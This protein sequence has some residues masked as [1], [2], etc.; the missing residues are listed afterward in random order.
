MAGPVK[1]WAVRPANRPRSPRPQLEETNNLQ[2]QLT[3]LQKQRLIEEERAKVLKSLG[4]GGGIGGFVDKTVGKAVRSGLDKATKPVRKIGSKAGAYSLDKLGDYNRRFVTPTAAWA[5]DG[6]MDIDQQVTGGRKLVIGEGTFGLDIQKRN[7]E[8]FG[9]HVTDQNNRINPIKAYMG[10]DDEIARAEEQMAKINPLLRMTLET[11]FDPTN[12]MTM[13]L[14]NVARL[15]ARSGVRLLGAT[16]EEVKAIESAIQARATRKSMNTHGLKALLGENDEVLGLLGKYGKA[17]GSS[18]EG[19]AKALL[20]VG[21]FAH[22]F[23]GVPE[24]MMDTFLRTGMRPL[25]KIPVLPSLRLSEDGTGLKIDLVPIGRQSKR[26][27]VEMAGEGITH[28]FNEVHQRAQAQSGGFGNQMVPSYYDPWDIERNAIA[29]LQDPATE[30][31]DPLAKQAL[32]TIHTGNIDLNKYAARLDNGE[33]PWYIQH[34]LGKEVGATRAKQLGLAVDK[35]D[36]EKLPSWQKF[37]AEKVARLPSGHNY[38]KNKLAATWVHAILFSP[39]Y[40]VQQPVT[41]AISSGMHYGMSPDIQRLMIGEV[42]SSIINRIVR[43]TGI[44]S[45]LGLKEGHLAEGLGVDPDVIAKMVANDDVYGATQSGVAYYNVAKRGQGGYLVESMDKVAGAA[46]HLPVVGKYVANSIS[47]GIRLPHATALANDEGFLRG[48]F[49]KF[50]G[51]NLRRYTVSDANEIVG[52]LVSDSDV[53]YKKLRNEAGLP[54]RLAKALSFGFMTS[55]NPAEFVDRARAISKI[56]PEKWAE[57]APSTDDFFVPLPIQNAAKERMAAGIQKGRYGVQGAM[58]TVKRQDYVDFIAETTTAQRDISRQAMSDFVTA[59]AP[60][61]HGYHNSMSQ[62]LDDLDDTVTLP[63]MR[64]RDAHK[65]KPTMTV[66]SRDVKIWSDV[67]IRNSYARV[68]HNTFMANVVEAYKVD[69]DGFM[70]NWMWNHQGMSNDVNAVKAELSQFLNDASAARY[71][72]IAGERAKWGDFRAKYDS[73]GVLP[74]E[75]D[76]D[77]LDDF[78]RAGQDRIWTEYYNRQYG[79]LGLANEHSS[80]VVNYTQRLFDEMD[81]MSRQVVGHMESQAVKSNKILETAYEIAYGKPMNP[82]IPRGATVVK[83]PTGPVIDP[84]V[85]VS[86]MRIESRH[87]FPLNTED[88]K[89]LGPAGGSTGARI[90]VDKNGQK[91]IL[92][93]QG[94]RQAADGMA[95][96]REE[97]LADELYRAMGVH[98]P[99]S[100]LYELGNGQVAKLSK[101]EEGTELGRLSG[102]AFERAAQKATGNF[103]V[104]V[105]LGNW[106]T[107]GL[108][109]DNM[110]LGADDILRRIDTGGSL[111]Y[112]AQGAP[113]G[114]AFG[115]VPGEMDSLR[116]PN[117]NPDAAQI[118]GKLTDD[119]IA[120]QI[121]RTL[122]PERRQALN[123]VLEAHGDAKLTATLNARWDNLAEYASVRGYDASAMPIFHLDENVVENIKADLQALQSE[124]VF[125]DKD[126][127]LDK[128]DWVNAI[129]DFVYGRGLSH[130]NNLI[131]GWQ[132]SSHK[133]SR[134]DYIYELIQDPEVERLR[135]ITRAAVEKAFPGQKTIKLWHG[136]NKKEP[137]AFAWTPS[138]ST[139]RGFAGN[140]GTNGI[141]VQRDVPIGAILA[142]PQ[143]HKGLASFG[144]DEYI[145]LPF[146]GDPDAYNKMGIDEILNQVIAD[147]P[148]G[149]AILARLN[150]HGILEQDYKLIRQMLFQPEHKVGSY[151]IPLIDSTQ[152]IDPRVMN[153]L[154]DEPTVGVMATQ[155]QR[156]FDSLKDYVTN[157][158]VGLDQRAAYIDAGLP[159]PPLNKFSN[160]FTSVDVNFG[161]VLEKIRNRMRYGLDAGDELITR[162]MTHV[163]ET[164]PPEIVQ[165]IE[166]AKKVKN[167]LGVR[168]LPDGYDTN[169]F[170]AFSQ[171]NGGYPLESVHYYITTGQSVDDYTIEKAREFVIK[172][173]NK[174][175]QGIPTPP[176][177]STMMPPTDTPLS[178]LSSSPEVFSISTP[179]YKFSTKIENGQDWINVKQRLEELVND[180]FITTAHYSNAVKELAVHKHIPPEFQTWADSFKNLIGTKTPTSWITEEQADNILYWLDEVHAKYKPYD[181]LENA[182]HRGNITEGK[183]AGI[184]IGDFHGLNVRFKEI[185]GKNFPDKIIINPF[186]VVRK[187]TKEW[188][189]MDDFSRKGF[190][191][192][193][194]YRDALADNTRDLIEQID[195]AFRAGDDIQADSLAWLARESIAEDYKAYKKVIDTYGPSARLDEGIEAQWDEASNY[196]S[197]VLSG[198][199]PKGNMSEYVG[200]RFAEEVHGVLVHEMAHQRFREHGGDFEQFV[201]DILDDVHV[202]GALRRAKDSY[203]NYFGEPAWNKMIA[204]GEELEQIGAFSQK[205]LIERIGGVSNNVAAKRAARSG[206]PEHFAEGGGGPPKG[207]HGPDVA[208]EG[209]IPP[210][211]PPPTGT[212]AAGGMAGSQPPKLPY[213]PIAH[214]TEEARAALA[215]IK[216]RASADAIDM[217]TERMGDFFMGRTNLDEFLSWWVPFSRFG[218][219]N[220]PMSMRSM[221]RVPGLAPAFA[222]WEAESDKQFTPT[223]GWLPIV[224]DV[225]GNPMGAMAQF[226]MF[227]SATGLKQEFGATWGEKAFSGAGNMGFGPGPIPQAGANLLG[228]SGLESSISPNLQRGVTEPLAEYIGGP[229]AI[230]NELLNRVSSL[231]YGEDAQGQLNREIEQTLADMGLNPNSVAE[232]SDEWNRAK[233]KT[234]A[235]R[236][237]NYI[238]AGATMRTIPP[239][240]VEYAK[241]TAEAIAAQGISL[242]AQRSLKRQGKNAWELLD[243]QQAQDVISQIGEEEFRRRAAVT[244][245]GLN[246][247]DRAKWHSIQAFY[248]ASN[249]HSAQ[250]DRELQT[251]GQLLLDGLIDGGEWRDRRKLSYAT[252][253][254]MSSASKRGAL[255]PSY[256]GDIRNNEMF[257]DEAVDAVFDEFKNAVRVA[258]GRDVNNTLMP[259]DEVLDAYKGI[260]PDGFADPITGDIDWAAWQSAKDVFV[261]QQPQGMRSYIQQYED[262]RISRDPAEELFQQAKDEMDI[263]NALPRFVG[264]SETESEQAQAA[265]EFEE[266]LTNAGVP[267]RMARIASMQKDPTGAILARIG[268]RSRNKARS[269]YWDEHPLLQLFFSSDIIPPEAQQYGGLPSPLTQIPTQ[270]IGVQ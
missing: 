177:D 194:K 84:T 5:V 252:Y 173:R 14:G 69:P 48:A 50:Y 86:A 268:R 236:L 59:E 64:F 138:E 105:L 142:S 102:D 97:A 38:F 183:F 192:L 24:I 42:N 128:D 146:Q 147:D 107:T 253:Y 108:G 259:Q 139:A 46:R 167:R 21:A 39:F 141:L 189:G 207:I 112:R 92:K 60:V 216:G 144:E 120:E 114:Q 58:D 90:V 4:S 193:P 264:L 185:T 63:R 170:T 187:I 210:Q 135:A 197:N 17:A 160:D 188:E 181:A 29:M 249:A 270:Q 77:A 54:N 256:G 250:L 164:T 117:I 65:K 191:P 208:D 233:R 28:L 247:A 244:P 212:G 159:V 83:G 136:G 95:H 228:I 109:L 134:W 143:S 26:S 132:G 53:I 12:L 204:H 19:M 231:V 44:S 73:Q 151:E 103:A 104:D 67:H 18:K 211:A 174:L 110:M 61:A 162:A 242:E 131:V 196:I 248:A 68:A 133:Y 198:P 239:E 241:K 70:D 124:G 56:S 37:F 172:K 74:V 49:E 171:A 15:S 130:L 175:T 6:I 218:T 96:L 7:R 265:I 266:S 156:Q 182:G 57:W 184:G 87:N 111:R 16:P 75:P 20:G 140:H 137:L 3:L 55:D 262:R 30:V 257:P 116:D 225:Y 41:N 153:A 178:Q 203:F 9:S 161:S 226:Q 223:P 220:I 165:Y 40:I 100:K 123:E 150:D 36:L 118:F 255:A 66:S 119:E 230:P 81:M 78:I 82:G 13:G 148:V 263:Y 195:A 80:I 91:Y 125:T 154:V 215:G 222:R 205:N 240:R 201:L 202:Q 25:G 71:T 51:D 227:R 199:A 258:A 85:N 260:R 127:L 115:D 219:R 94:G 62:V 234:V 126:F 243:S 98:V 269:S 267:S 179:E 217:G 235:N 180:G 93:A 121:S 224:G 246:S 206:V 72:G 31:Y 113:K 149:A 238:M 145:V 169:S 254:A 79:R 166:D 232:G 200:E 35:A 176:S 221:A 47:G 229:A 261:L 129:D 106:D 33:H 168:E 43:D 214:R 88:L 209:A 1:W 76:T 190:W 22:F 163:D 158:M 2:N 186:S 32:E 34:D 245:M 152:S 122:T 11:I 89:D 8:L 237:S 155:I 213:V 99:E 27:Q 251:N 23:Q 52:R 101:F 10:D 45:R 157:A